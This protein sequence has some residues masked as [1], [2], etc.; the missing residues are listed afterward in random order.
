MSTYRPNE[1]AKLIAKTT[2]TLQRWDREGLGADR[3]RRRE[4]YNR[5]RRTNSEFV[6]LFARRDVQSDFRSR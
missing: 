4:R 1:F 6:F 5:G 3:L 2:S